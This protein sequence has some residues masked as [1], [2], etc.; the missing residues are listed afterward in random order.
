MLLSKEE[1]S[2]LGK[3]AKQIEQNEKA[4]KTGILKRNL[5]EKILAFL[6]CFS[7]FFSNVSWFGIASAS[8]PP[9]DMS[10]ALAT[11]DQSGQVSFGNALINTNMIKD[12]PYA[13]EAIVHSPYCQYDLVVQASDDLKIDGSSNVI[14]IENLHWRLKKAGI[15]SEWNPFATSQQTIVSNECNGDSIYYLDYGLFLEDEDLPW[16]MGT[17]EYSTTITYS[18]FP[19]Y[20]I[21]PSIESQIADTDNGGLAN[22][23]SSDVFAV[24]G[25]NPDAK[26]GSSTETKVLG[27]ASDEPEILQNQESAVASSQSPE[28]QG[29]ANEEPQTS[30]NPGS[31]QIESEGNQEESYT[32]TESSTSTEG[33]D[34][35]PP[36]VT[37][38]SMP[39]G[40]AQGVLDVRIAT[41]DDVEVR[42]VELFVDG[43]KVD[44]VVY[45]EENSCYV[46]SWDTT[47]ETE[48]EHSLVAKAYDAAGNEGISNEALV[49]INNPP[50][51]PTNLTAT[52]SEGKINL[53]WTPN[54]EPDIAGYNVYKRVAGEDEYQKLTT[55][56]VLE[57]S[58][59]DTSVGPETTY[60]YIVKA[61]DDTEKESESSNEVV[62]TFPTE[63][64]AVLPNSNKEQAEAQLGVE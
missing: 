62:I 28:A 36:K 34:N 15:I 40:D 61:V 14:P 13:V 19:R 59:D 52:P 43:A 51:A 11:P 18:L 2:L 41:I 63:L 3:L 31:N 39:L 50:R 35:S 1:K 26:E 47:T 20:E 24:T 33:Q 54:S 46:Y 44:G 6:L 37:F 29:M 38:V 4:G 57:N 25:S 56:L 23:S 12:T 16:R 49:Q 32:S 9:D 17:G 30:Q 10:L 42:E 48:G 21:S 58:F 64:A 22:I 45:D 55:N 7:L 5:S 53:V 27:M 60:Y 8:Y